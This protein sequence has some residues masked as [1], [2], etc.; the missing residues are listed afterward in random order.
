MNEMQKGTQNT[1]NSLQNGIQNVTNDDPNA[2]NISSSDTEYTAQRTSSETNGDFFSFMNDN[3]W[4]W[5]VIG[6]VA[7]VVL[8]ILW[9]YMARKNNYSNHDE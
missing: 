1:I 5:I 9:Y 6:I 8:G 3:V 7:I 4:A 2:K